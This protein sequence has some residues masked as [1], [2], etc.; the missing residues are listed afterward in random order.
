MIKS[1]AYYSFLSNNQSR[2][3]KKENQMKIL[4]LAAV[5]ATSGCAAMTNGTT[6]DLRFPAES[7]RFCEIYRG[8]EN[9]G[10]YGPE[11][12][13]VTVKRSQD[14]ITIDCGNTTKVVEAEITPAGYT[15]LFLSPDFGLTDYFFTS[16]AWGYRP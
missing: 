15:S 7:G 4:L 1:L 13:T 3:T 5:L 16:A 12:K 14:P 9:L 2:S 10:F 11:P 8:D 6:Q